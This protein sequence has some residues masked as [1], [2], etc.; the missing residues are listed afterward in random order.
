MLLGLSGGLAACSGVLGLDELSPRPAPEDQVNGRQMP[1]VSPTD[2]GT[3]DVDGVVE[4]PPDTRVLASKWYHTCAAHPDGVLSCFG[5]NA[6]GELGDGT[7][8]DRTAPTLVPG[9]PAVADVATGLEHTCILQRDGVVRCWGSNGAGQLGDG[10][11]TPRTSVGAPV[12]GSYVY[13]SAGMYHTCGLTT[14]RAVRC[15]GDNYFG[16]IGD[17]TR[18][19]RSNATPVP[20][21]A[22][23]VSLA[24]GGW[25]TC[26]AVTNGTVYCWGY[27]RYGQVGYATSQED[28]EEAH[29]EVATL[30]PGLDHVI[31]LTAGEHHTC[32][33]RDDRTVWC[34]GRNDEHAL[35]DGTEDETRTIPAPTVGDLHDVAEVVAGTHNTC[36]RLLDGTVRCWGRNP[37][38]ELA[39]GNTDPGTSVPS[40]PIVGLTGIE[41]LT[42]G[43]HGCAFDGADAL[44]CWGR[45]D[46]GQLGLDTGGESVLTPALV[47]F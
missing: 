3:R 25:H 44:R 21:V 9:I 6:H 4:S 42:M 30:V 38:G 24:T 40:L 1:A 39:N 28:E 11:N 15:W 13:V 37:F 12:A 19:H 31:Q 2:A 32:A 10:T 35:G 43:D 7:T 17:G 34:W 29:S 36:A 20:G 45:N 23:V 26:A 22:N 41:R 33:L 14:D 47:P 16:S 46:H 18:E 8:Y 5:S 27:N